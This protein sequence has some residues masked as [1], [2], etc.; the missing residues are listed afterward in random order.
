MKPFAV[1]ADSHTPLRSQLRMLTPN[2]ANYFQ[3]WGE[4]ARWFEL[5]DS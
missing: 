3:V 2:F 4:I 1:L 5:P